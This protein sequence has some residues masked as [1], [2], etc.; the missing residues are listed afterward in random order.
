MI[1]LIHGQN[2]PMWR[3]Y[4]R[5]NSPS[6]DNL[7]AENWNNSNQYGSPD[8]INSATASVI[9]N[10]SIFTKIYPNP[11]V[12]N[13]YLL[14]E[15]DNQDHT[16]INLYDIK[17]SLVSEIFDGEL[18]SGIHRLNRNFDYLNSGIYILKII[19]SSGKVQTEKLIKF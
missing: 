11:F 1:H 16:K 12:N 19:T 5:A 10:N 8:E 13:L 3:L 14:F 7:L 2:L 6:L 9:E 15:L 18:S 4:I 17:G